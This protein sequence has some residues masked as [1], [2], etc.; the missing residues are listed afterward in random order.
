MSLYEYVQQGGPIMYVL[1]F[2]NIIGFGIMGAKLIVF[3]LESKKRGSVIA[4]LV[5]KLKISYKLEPNVLAEVCRQEVSRYIGSIEKGLNT[6]KIIAAISPLLGLLGTVLGVLMAFRV[7]SETGLDNPANFAKG[8]SM[9]LITTVGGLLVAIPNFVGAQL[10]VGYCWTE[11]RRI[12]KKNSWVTHCCRW[13]IN[14]KVRR[15]KAIARSR[16]F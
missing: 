9:A 5:S 11:S 3:I 12:W 4:N 6:V 1:L 7:M 10:F 2:L 13:K 16:C 14:R 8:I 15:E